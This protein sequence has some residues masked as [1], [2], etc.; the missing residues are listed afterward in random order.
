MCASNQ[1]TVCSGSV[2]GRARAVYDR[3]GACK[4]QR[5]PAFLFL[6]SIRKPPELS[7]LENNM[8]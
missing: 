6:S 8:L 4:Q 5:S 7:E 3:G 2:L 1:E